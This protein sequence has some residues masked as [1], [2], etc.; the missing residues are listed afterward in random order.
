[1]SIFLDASRKS[2]YN[3]AVERHA[4]VEVRSFLADITK[5]VARALLVC[6]DNA[7]TLTLPPAVATHIQRVLPDFSTED[8]VSPRGTRVLIVTPTF[9]SLYVSQGLLLSS[10]IDEVTYGPSDDKDRFM[11][12]RGF[13]VLDACEVAT[14]HYNRLKGANKWE[15]ANAVKN[16][17]GGVEMIDDMIGEAI[18]SRFGPNR[19]TCGKPGHRAYS[20]PILSTQT[21]A[22]TTVHPAG[23]PLS[24]RTESRL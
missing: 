1:V 14:N 2:P 6:L 18:A 24:Q 17:T 22:Q 11:E 15:A 23:V 10:A 20:N 19:F 5:Q 7:L 4:S 21:V 16:L 8:K 9:K 3:V 13:G 12:A